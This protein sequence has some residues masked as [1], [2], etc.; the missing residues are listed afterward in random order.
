LTQKNISFGI[1]AFLDVLGFRNRVSKAISISD[2]DAIA[3]DLRKIQSEFGFK[4]KDDLIKANHS[5]YKKTVLA[6]SDSVVV[7]VSLQSEATKIIGTFDTIILELYGM[8]IAQSNC[9]SS[10]LFLRGGVDC[11]FWYR[12]GF[13]LISKSF[14]G[15]YRAEQLANV[16]IIALT[17]DLYQF[18]S[19]H[20]DRKIYSKDIEPVDQL[21]RLYKDGN[22]SFWYLDYLTIFANQGNMAAL[23]VW[24][25][26]HART[27]EKAYQ[28]STKEEFE[29]ESE[30]EKVMRKYAWLA[31]YHNEIAQKFTTSSECQCDLK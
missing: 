29:S 23:T 1:T 5:N 20:P 24:F 16:P 19:K 9:V 15:A 10:G 3:K 17:N 30:R 13:T 22:V 27:V 25:T 11:G 26:H 7:N 18:L 31:S 2:I 21:L 8:A 14:I 6:F 4:P 28:Q 12:R